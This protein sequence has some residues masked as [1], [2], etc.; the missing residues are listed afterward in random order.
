MHSVLNELASIPGLTGAFVYQ[1]KRG[2]SENTLPSS[3]T[4][5]KIQ[6]I[7]KALSKIHAAG[8]MNFPDLSD[9]VLSSDDSTV[10]VRDLSEKAWVVLMGE[11]TLNVNMAAVSLHVI[12]ED[13]KEALAQGEGE[14]TQVPQTLEPAPKPTLSTKELMES[15]ILGP[16]LQGMLVA[17]AK[18]V[19]PMAGIIFLECLER[20]AEE[21]NPQKENLPKLLALLVQETGDSANAARYRK[22]VEPL[23]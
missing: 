13:L 16:I 10:F 7:G 8:S 9:I 23:L 22:L 6:V 19:G 15:P 5:A 1:A 14:S 20:W 2:I 3:F 11:P 4:P 18:V 12:L 17:L 21:A